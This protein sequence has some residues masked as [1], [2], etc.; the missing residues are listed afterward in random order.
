MDKIILASASPRRQELLGLLVERFEV[1]PSGADES[2]PWGT[3]PADAVRLLALR[4]AREVAGRCPGALVIGADTVVDLDGKILGKPA[5]ER[6]AVQMLLALS[7]RRH[8][9]H[10][11][12]ALVDGD[13]ERA[14]TVTTE[15]AFAPVTEA[16]ARWY[17]ATG[18]PLDKAGAYGIQGLGCRC[19]AST[20]CSENRACRCGSGR[21]ECKLFS[22]RGFAVEKTVQ[23]LYNRFEA[24]THAEQSIVRRAAWR[25]TLFF[26][27]QVYLRK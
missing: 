21:K 10:T 13:G 19:A 11:G 27:W 3:P 14:D 8:R 12:I 25:L 16:E 5:G 24:C 26:R 18:E 7:G 15:V 4:K 22:K 20:S 23:P 2:L 1:V 6:E 9:V 17:A